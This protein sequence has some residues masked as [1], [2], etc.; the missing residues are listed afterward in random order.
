M[1]AAISQMSTSD[2]NT[3]T[4]AALARVTWHD[5]TAMEWSLLAFPFVCVGAVALAMFLSKK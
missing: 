5:M 2:L 1:S 4:I 3:A